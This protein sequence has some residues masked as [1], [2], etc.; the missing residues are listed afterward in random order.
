MERQLS[1]KV[2]NRSA[3]FS[4]ASGCGSAGQMTVACALTGG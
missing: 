2:L 4:A 1:A 3:S